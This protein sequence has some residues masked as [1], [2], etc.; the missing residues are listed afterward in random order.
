[1]LR[2]LV[3]GIALAAIGCD[4]EYDDQEGNPPLF[5]NGARVGDAPPEQPQPELGPNGMPVVPTFEPGLCAPDHECP[6]ALPQPQ[7]PPGMQ[8]GQMPPGMQPGQM[9]PGMQPGQMP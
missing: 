5:A 1:M 7:L 9:P 6:M 2:Y 3:V 8:P 4:D